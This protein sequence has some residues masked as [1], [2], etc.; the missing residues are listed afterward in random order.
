MKKVNLSKLSKI[1]VRFKSCGY[2]ES[3]A[4]LQEIYNSEYEDTLNDGGILGIDKCK[5]KLKVKAIIFSEFN[6]FKKMLDNIK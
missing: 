6:S 4:I 2:N 3:A 5:E 1:I